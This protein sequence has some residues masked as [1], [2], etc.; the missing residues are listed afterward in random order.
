MIKLINSHESEMICII[1]FKLIFLYWR[2]QVDYIVYKF[3]LKILKWNN[4]PTYHHRFNIF[5]IR[6]LITESN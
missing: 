6:K 3:W 2:T 4:L 1:E 5:C